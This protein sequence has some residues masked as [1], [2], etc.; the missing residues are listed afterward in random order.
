MMLQPARLTKAAQAKA[1][2]ARPVTIMPPVEGWDASSALASM[3][4]KR[5]ARPARI[6]MAGRGMIYDPLRSSVLANW[7]RDS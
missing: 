4:P 7:R 3:G 5:A 1:P 6:G 2:I